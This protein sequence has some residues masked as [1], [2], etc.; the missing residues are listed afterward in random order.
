MKSWE[1]VWM[2]QWVSNGPVS[3]ILLILKQSI[4]GFVGDVAQTLLKIFFPTKVAPELQIM[5]F[6]M[7]WTKR[8]VEVQL[9]EQVQAAV[10]AFMETATKHS[11]PLYHT[12]I[13][14]VKENYEKQSWWSSFPTDQ[15]RDC[16]EH[17]YT[18]LDDVEN[19]AG[20]I[21]SSK[22]QYALLPTYLVAASLRMSIWRE[23]YN[24]KIWYETATGVSPDSPDHRFAAFN[25]TAVLQ[26]MKEI[27]QKT[28]EDLMELRIAWQM[29]RFPQLELKE[30]SGQIELLDKLYNKEIVKTRWFVNS[31]DETKFALRQRLLNQHSA[32]LVATELFPSMK[33]FS[34]LHNLIPGQEK[35]PPSQ[36]PR[37]TPRTSHLPFDWEL[38]NDGAL[39]Y[40]F[41]STFH[42][43]P[44]SAWYVGAR[45]SSYYDPLTC[46]P[47]HS[48]S[49]FG[50]M[51]RV[52][53][54]TGDIIDELHL[55]YWPRK[56]IGSEDEFIERSIGDEGKGF[57]VMPQELPSF[58]CGLDISYHSEGQMMQIAFINFKN[59][60]IA[61][62]GNHARSEVHSKDAK[63]V[64]LGP[65][66][67][68]M[69]TF[70]QISDFTNHLET[71]PAH[72]MTF[73][74]TWKAP[75]PESI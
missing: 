61:I 22:Y 56:E 36:G 14:T 4:G 29:H 55:W 40:V 41:P 24:T 12:C 34:V 13:K 43:G 44:L 38:Q 72:A 1:E 5:Q 57:E 48:E 60:S 47:D 74:F 46:C 18:A 62:R 28:A 21:M 73:S 31:G 35:E 49:A 16:L 52:G 39:W 69:Y 63:R 3:V 9:I 8:Y 27:Y 11:L 53:G 71:T 66:L 75:P 51:G 30:D 17:L 70:H 54:S 58:T 10:K 64:V 37:I 65:S 68:Q 26:Q 45:V 2:N 19:A 25:S 32:F 67:C 42:V 59:E 20:N 6:L 50:S 7:D 15:L 23:N 33:P